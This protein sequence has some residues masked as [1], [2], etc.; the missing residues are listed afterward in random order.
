MRGRLLREIIYVGIQ[1]QN[2]VVYCCLVSSIVVRMNIGFDNNFNCINSQFSVEFIRVKISQNTYD[3][4]Q[5]FIFR[6][7]DFFYVGDTYSSPQKYV[8]KCENCT[9]CIL[10]A[11]RRTTVSI[12]WSCR[13]TNFTRIGNCIILCRIIVDSIY[14]LLEAPRIG[15]LMLQSYLILWTSWYSQECFD[16]PWLLTIEMP[17]VYNTTIYFWLEHWILQ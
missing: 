17:V 12:S 15:Y 10:K 3:Y 16:L 1:L 2:L 5:H 6:S 11:Y 8:I 13:P 4:T 7:L 14:C 9:L